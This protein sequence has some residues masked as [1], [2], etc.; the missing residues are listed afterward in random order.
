[1]NKIAQ[2]LTLVFLVIGLNSN[3]Q[4]IVWTGS[5]SNNDFFDENNWRNS[6]T[7]LTPISG[8]IT[9]AVAINLPLKINN[10]A[11][12]II[13]NGEINLGTG[14]LTISMAMLT[15]QSFSGTG[16][17]LV[18]NEGAYIDLSERVPFKTSTIQ[19][20]FTSGI[21]WIRTINATPATIRDSYREQIKVNGTITKREDLSTNLSKLRL[22]NY[23][24]KGCVI[25]SN[26]ANTSPLTVYDSEN[27][28]G[29][30][31]KITVNTIHK[32]NA[33]ANNMNNKIAS[34]TL[35]KGYMVTIAVE[36]D[37]TG[38]SKNY[39][40]SEKDLVINT[41]PKALKNLISFI[42][43]M[44]WNWVSKKGVNEVNDVGFQRPGWRYQWNGNESSTP[45]YEFAPM[46]WGQG[47]AD[48]D[49]DIANFVK[50]YNTTHVMSFN[51]PDDCEGQSGQYG[52]PKLCVVDEAVKWHKNLAKTGM[53]LVSPGG[54]EEAPFG[55]LKD[56]Y[57]KATA[58]NVRIDVIAVHWYDWGS[59][60]TVNKTP[61]AQQVFDRFKA[62]LTRVH[63][64]YGLPIWITEFNANPAR[65]Q[66]INAGFLALALPYLESLD[67]I[68][69]YCWF[70]FNVG[71]HF[72]GWRDA[73]ATT[74]R[75]E[76]DEILS[77]VGTIYKNISNTKPAFSLPSIPEDVIDA[78]NNLNLL[79]YP[80][81]AL[82]KPVIANSSFSSVYD[83]KNAVDGNADSQW[84]V[85]IKVPRNNNFAPLPASLV[86]DLNG[87]YTIDSFRTIEDL[88]SSK[89]F[90]FDVWD[91][92]INS[93]EGGWR[94]VV[95]V[96]E[97]PTD[98]LT[99]FKT[100]AP[101]ITTKVRLYI[102][103]HNS[104]ST[105]R[106]SELEVFG[107]LETTLDVKQYVSNQSFSLYPNPATNIINI[108]GDE[109]VSNVEVFDIQGSKI[110]IPFENGRLSVQGLSTGVYFLK[111]NKQ[112]T[113]KF[114]KK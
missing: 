55:W 56:F 109:E 34:F 46:S 68:E 54:R 82:N 102:T 13:A 96:T 21:G 90:S 49:E 89:S 76:T 1:M 92:S 39:I 33:I 97:N 19:I 27:L 111:I 103:D 12:I 70:P 35:K 43:V 29:N 106:F 105:M 17:S 37:G 98:A 2:F 20:N 85:N 42:R 61:T 87:T 31:A 8:S 83:A 94:S 99:T 108:I 44:P 73:T 3:A 77:L 100:F 41:F 72:S 30:S 95:N 88:N 64:L 93:G 15:A 24:I 69:R 74:P 62:Y 114:I 7:D 50:L 110:N 75:Q 57:N 26:E 10:I 71:T 45:D 5:A 107:K 63:D 28:Q 84:W 36:E 112:Y 101:E 65:S 53:R 25:R 52:T 86:V 59:D 48:S 67:Y 51:E 16:G 18:V 47:T 113:F 78:N 80:N 38:S 81:V 14:S 6:I 23:Y 66:A 32:G 22:D 60:P 104:P 11:A 4:D 58:Q 40:A 9:P 79:S 91:L